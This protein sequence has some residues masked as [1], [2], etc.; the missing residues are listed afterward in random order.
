MK[1]LLP[2]L[3]LSAS[4]LASCGNDSVAGMYSFLLGRQGENETRVGINIELKDEKYVIPAGSDITH[5]AEEIALIEQR[6]KKFTLS[7]DLGSEFDKIMDALG[8]QDGL[9]GYYML[10]DDT[11]EKYGQ[12]MALGMD[13]DF[14]D[15]DLPITSELIKNLIVSYVGG[16][17]ITLQ[18]PVSIEDLQ[19][20]LC[21]YS[22][23]YFDFDPYIKS[24]IH[25]L[26]D[27]GT[28]FFDIIETRKVYD[29]TTISELPGPTGEKRFGSHPKLDLDNDG[30]EKE[31]S[32]EVAK[33]NEKYAGVF[34]N[35]YVYAVGDLGGR[36][37]VIGSVYQVQEGKTTYDLFYPLNGYNP[38]REF[39][40]YVVAEDLLSTEDVKVHLTLLND[41]TS[42][43]A[44]QTIGLMKVVGNQ[45]SYVD[46]E[47]MK[48]D[49][50]KR[51]AFTFRDF[52]DIKV[53]L[54]KE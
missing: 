5:S 29:L 42:E 52:H 50:Y 34:S 16:G 1:K 4:C 15:F 51:D 10:L 41:A 31:N 21:W 13:F 39:D 7:L 8:L 35:T 18:V 40:G 6:A 26:E 27:L 32:G 9:G 33:M 36:G 44:S 53:Q 45:G 38:D 24:K 14:E 3:L 30:K 12:K 47:E 23:Q 22:G 20:Q 28:Y 43:D 46:G 11:D 19:Y 37:D 2:L 48:Y 54:T 49:Y 17:K 25:D